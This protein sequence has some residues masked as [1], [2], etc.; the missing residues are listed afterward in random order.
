M[1]T[2]IFILAGIQSGHI[3]LSLGVV[4]FFWTCI[5]GSLGNLKKKRKINPIDRYG[6]YFYGDIDWLRKNKL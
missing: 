6:D 3:G 2:I 1:F 5:L 4:I